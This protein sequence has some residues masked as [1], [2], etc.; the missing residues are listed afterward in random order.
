LFVFYNANS[1]RCEKRWKKIAW[2]ASLPL[3]KAQHLDPS[4]GPKRILALDGGG[5]R[6]I[7]TLQFL[8][9][10]E[11]LIKKRFGDK[12]LLCDYFDLIGGTSTG[13]IIAAGLACGMTVQALEDLYKNI[14]AKVFQ[15]EWWSKYALKGV[16]APKFPSEPLQAE[17][18]RQLGAGT[19]LDSDKI[20]T[21]LMIMAK[22]L[23]TG[24][25]WPLNNG[26]R[27]KYAAQD[28]ALRLTQIVRA[29]TAAPTYFAPEAIRI[30]R[31]DG[32]SV[33]GAFVDGG[34]TPFN[35]PT[36]QLLMLAALQGHGFCWPAGK[37]NL[38]LISIGTGRYQQ[39][40]TAEDLL[41][42]PAAQQGITSL[43]S[44]MDDCERMN[45][46]TLQW[47]TNCLTPWIIDRAVGDMKLDSQSGPQLATYVR[48]N[49]ILEPAWLMTELGLDLA[50]D[51]LEQI[52]KMD[53]P[54][55][56]SDLADLGRLAAAKQVKPEHL[57]A[58]FDLAKA[59]A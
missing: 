42:A 58:S 28:G 31:R 39:T 22:R 45:R 59:S 52:R 21:G 51:K 41:R 34:I 14:G 40:H 12:T 24:S 50:A 55:N 5:I 27:G 7:L 30:S 9:A 56:L 35:D 29:S 47:L 18:D 25:P 57:P 15:T 53:D 36:L 19:T 23:D 11:S 6:G 16:L 2:E 37:N 33:D 1:P 10:I 3:T 44:L 20:L 38:L 13:S 48:Y 17:L 46:A 4:T 8:Q 43:Q 32:T 54:S 49:A 26:G